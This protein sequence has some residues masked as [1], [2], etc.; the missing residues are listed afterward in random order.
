MP[1]TNYDL[2]VAKKTL[3]CLCLLV[4][5]SSSG[6]QVLLWATKIVSEKWF[7]FVRSILTL[8]ITIDFARFT[9]QAHDA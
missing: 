4:T 9:K 1:A 8:I 3:T 2:V 7:G 6:A 5:Q